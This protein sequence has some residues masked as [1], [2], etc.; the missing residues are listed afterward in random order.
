MGDL[1]SPSPAPELPLIVVSAAASGSGK[2]PWVEAL[3]HALAGRGLRVGVVKHHP[4]GAGGNDDDTTD[5]G[6]AARAGARARI[7]AEPGRLSLFIDA[8]DARGL[9]GLGVRMLAASRVVDVVLAEGFRALPARAR[10]W[11][12][13][14]APDAVD[15]VCVHVE[16][17]QSADADRVEAALD[18][19]LSAWQ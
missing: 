7:L 8:R 10:L 6:R 16:A 11:V 9:L 19:L 12:G 17:A 1:G 3:T 14:G 15:R 18:R 13:D 5:T 2:T 4:H